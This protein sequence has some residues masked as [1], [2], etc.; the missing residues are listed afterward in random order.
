MDVPILYRDDALVVVEKPSGMLVHRSQGSRDPV[1]VMTFVRD[2][3]GAHVHPVHRLDRQTSGLLIVALTKDASRI[4]FD[5]F[6]R[7]RVAKR[8]LAMVHGQPPR[9][10]RIDT[11]LLKHNGAWQEA[12]TEFVTLQGHPDCSLLLVTPTQG[13]RH[14]IRR[15]FQGIGHPLF[16]DDQY[17]HPDGADRL[18]LHACELQF[19]HPASGDIMSFASA[20]PADLCDISQ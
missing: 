6:Q 12:L 8:Y 1:T 3:V 15:H 5:S 7:G 2:V 17:G 16:G 9:Q 20:L 11:P 10:G 4:L 13:R 18:A 19:P 14:Q